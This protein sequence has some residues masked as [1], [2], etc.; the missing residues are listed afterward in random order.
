MTIITKYVEAG[1]TTHWNFRSEANM[2]TSVRLVYCLIALAFKCSPSRSCK[3]WYAEVPF[4]KRRGPPRK[5][6]A[7]IETL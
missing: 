4:I 7:A 6:I 1:E 3:G 2:V 5:Y